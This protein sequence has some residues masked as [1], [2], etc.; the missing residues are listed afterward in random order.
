MR[1]SRYIR[2]V[3]HD[4]DPFPW[5]ILQHSS[6][7]VPKKHRSDTECSLTRFDPTHSFWP[8]DR[9]VDNNVESTFSKCLLRLRTPL[10]ESLLA[11]ITDAHGFC[12]KSVGG[13]QLYIRYIYTYV[14]RITG[15]SRDVF[16]NT[17]TDNTI[18]QI[19]SARPFLRNFLYT[20]SSNRKETDYPRQRADC[21]N[22]KTSMER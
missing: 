3:R 9:I 20:R 16:F 15:S 2:L 12:R 1:L 17:A 5:W 19:F 14:H 8:A 22:G 10:R 7:A 11:D 18:V 21:L 4:C 13:Q 6:R